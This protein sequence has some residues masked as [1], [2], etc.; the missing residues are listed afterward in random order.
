MGL[1]CQNIQQNKT[2]FSP[3]GNPGLQLLQSV[4]CAAFVSE[5]YFIIN[6]GLLLASVRLLPFM[7]EPQ[8]QALRLSCS[9]FKTEANTKK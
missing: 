1:K 6:T 2:T 8:I 9:F 4:G 3:V 7:S 5:M